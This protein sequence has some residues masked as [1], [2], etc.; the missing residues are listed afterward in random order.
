MNEEMNISLNLN[1]FTGLCKLGFFTM[2]TTNGRSDL[3]F[4]KTDIMDLIN[5]KIVEKSDYTHNYN[6]VLVPIDKVDLVETIKRSPIFMELAS[7]L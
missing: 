2:N 5:G 3:Q 1:M 7:T 6:F 4:Y